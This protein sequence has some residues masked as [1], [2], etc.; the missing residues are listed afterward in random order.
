MRKTIYSGIVT[1]FLCL[2]LCSCSTTYTVYS[3]NIFTGKKLLEEKEYAESRKY[4][5]EAARNIRD[6]VSLTFLAVAE[7]RTGNLENA[8]RLIQEAA[9]EELDVL[10]F[11]RTFGYK[12]IIVMKQD[13]AA[14]IVALKDYINRYNTVYPLKTIKDLRKMVEAGIV[15]EARME[16]IINEQI[17]WYERDM[18]EFLTT[19]GGYYGERYSGSLFISR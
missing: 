10:Y 5:Q 16:T 7:Y 19:G 17:W 13:R 6:S 4:F 8:G 14:G 15:D 11:V 9:R 12:A 18:E 1:V 2:A 3:Q